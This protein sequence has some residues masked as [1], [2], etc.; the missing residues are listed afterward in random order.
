M[1][2]MILS[3]QPPQPVEQLVSFCTSANSFS[4]SEK[5][6]LKGLLERYF[7]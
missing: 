7:K 3:W 5:R 2:A 6:A 4:T 1:T